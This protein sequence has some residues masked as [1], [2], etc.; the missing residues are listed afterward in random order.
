MA[1]N[2]TLSRLNTHITSLQANPATTPIDT[3]LFEEAELVLPEYI[4]KQETFALVQQLSALL[5][6]IQQNPTPAVNLL[7]RL[8]NPF[9]FSDVLS[10]DPPVN[11]DTGLDVGLD[12]PEG[13]MLPFNRLML[14][15]LEKAT[16]SSSD[17]ATVAAKPEVVQAMVKLWLCSADTGVSTTASKLLID[18]LRV[19]HEVF[20]HPDQQVPSGGQGLMWKRVFGDRNVYG[21]FFE[22]CSFRT[23][24]L[25][26]SKNQR[27]LAQA[28][29]LEW[30]PTVAR[31]DW[32]AVSRSHHADVEAAS[33]LADGEGLLDFA[34]MH[35]VDF[36]DDV[37]MY[38]CLIDFYADLLNIMLEKETP[39]TSV[40]KSTALDYLT[41][42]GLHDR[43]AKIYL[44]SQ[45]EMDVMESM[46]LYGPSANY[47]AKYAELYPRHFQASSM[48]KKVNARL[49]EAL[50]M[51]FAKWAH[52]ESPKH[53]LHL[54]ASLPRATLLPSAEG[55]AAWATTPVS[56]L[57]SKVTNPDALNTLATIFHGPSRKITTFPPTSPMTD[58][59]SPQEELEAAAARALY[60]NYLANNSNLWS[61]IT[62]HSDT[63]A[64]K[65]LALSALNCLQAVIT[66]NW[67]TKPSLALPT[68]TMATP[69][70]GHL[71]ILSPPALEYTLPYL[72]KP[73]QTFAN[74]VGGRG[75]SESSAYKVAT[76]KWDA[77]KALHSALVTQVEL[78][79]GQGFE[80]ILA[81]LSKRLAAGTM[82]N[83]GEIGGRIET[84]QL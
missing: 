15:L 8:L 62:T 4:N 30:L 81:T 16:A 18:L 49:M 41:E 82:T 22:A 64:L 51:S 35:M 36:A 31:M 52:S 45:A 54:L 69:P 23:Q 56:L 17:A 68:S 1:Q 32:G 34:A 7:I 21:T 3:R 78:E 38:R 63:V 61:D 66:A 55:P 10:F 46:F 5:Q 43:T 73:A 44:Q 59:P 74:L 39:T 79:P 13:V 80:D 19:D 60:M 47:L 9:A 84:V 29:L 14:A 58:E 27:T 53:D 33:G 2:T 57:P 75:D 37:L 67:S 77:L 12:A 65:D 42:K 72:I 76:A 20:D 26:L 6:D 50:A 24:V 83:E 11:F 70:S 28:R 48:H 25:K 40:E 71:A